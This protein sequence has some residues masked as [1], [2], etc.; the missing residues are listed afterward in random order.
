MTA[1]N[2][3][4]SSIDLASVR[5]R[6]TSL[7]DAFLE[8]KERQARSEGLPPGPPATL[9]GFIAAGGK[10]LRPLVCVLGWQV[11]GGAGVPD[12]VARTAAALE[13]YQSFALIHDDVIDNSATRRFQPTV[14]RALARQYPQAS[15]PRHLGISGAIL[16]GN[17]ALAWSDELITGADLPPGCRAAVGRLIDAMREEM[18]YGQYL[19]LLATMGPIADHQTPLM[20][21][22]Y[23]T[24]LYTIERPLQIGAALAGASAE[25][26]TMLGRF[27]LPVGEAF[28]LRDDLLGVFGDPGLTGKP[29]LDDLREGKHTVLLALAAQRADAAQSRVLGRLVGDP[30]LSEDGASTIREIFTATQAPAAVE[31]M[32]EH[33]CTAALSVLDSAP[34]SAD[35]AAVLRSVV[36]LAVERES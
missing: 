6:V 31:D 23:K 22:R 27:A 3:V 19:E 12:M 30:E 9:R 21:L 26:L 20:V 24:A 11:A 25:L 8:N 14:H 35:C 2:R 33:R 36:A 5:N 29:V 10:R 4:T 1:P 34:I 18:H 17:M 16:I 7:L 15:D 13:L 32:I 28:Q